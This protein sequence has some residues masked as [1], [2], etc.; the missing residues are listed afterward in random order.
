MPAVRHVWLFLLLLHAVVA[1]VAWRAGAWAGFFSLA[2]AHLCWVAVTLWPGSTPFGKARQSF[3][4]SARELILTIDDGPGAD[5][6]AVLDLLDRYQAKAVFF[7]IGQR[8]DAQPDYVRE[9]ARRGHLVENHTLTHPSASFWA[10]GPARLH[11]EIRGGSDVIGTLAGRTPVWFRA[12]AGFR[13]PFTAPILKNLGL[14]YLGWTARGFD[15]R[16]KSVPRILARLRRGFRPGAVL[17]IHQGH[18]H[19]VAVLEALLDALGAEG[20]RIILPSSLAADKD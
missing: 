6:P 7:V 1:I 3:P 8:A 16:Q 2:A 5:T 10:A 13:N 4:V 15:T 18:P 17:L 20:W 9:T 19:S 11:R 14:H 12:P